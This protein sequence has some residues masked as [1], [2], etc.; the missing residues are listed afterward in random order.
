MEDEAGNGERL[1][2]GGMSS[3]VRKGL[4]MRKVLE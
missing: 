3:E 1:C 4:R 2:K